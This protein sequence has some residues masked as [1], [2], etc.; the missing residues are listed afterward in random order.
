VGIDLAI[1]IIAVL[2]GLWGVYVSRSSSKKDRSYPHTVNQKKA[3][4][5]KYYL[6]EKNDTKLVALNTQKNCSID[7]RRIGFKKARDVHVTFTKAFKKSLSIC[8]AHIIWPWSFV[9]RTDLP[10]YPFKKTSTYK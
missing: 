9:S 8:V 3:H 4:E 2:V 10:S 6:H 7:T 5:H 1:Q